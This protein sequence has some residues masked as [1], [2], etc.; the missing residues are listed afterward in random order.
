MDDVFLTLEAN[1]ADTADSDLLSREPIYPRST[2]GGIYTMIKIITQATLYLR[3]HLAS[4]G[5]EG[6]TSSGVGLRHEPALAAIPFSVIFET[7]IPASFSLNGV[8]PRPPAML[9]PRTDMEK[10]LSVFQAF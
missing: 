10:S 6:K 7:K 3:P 9:K 4:V 8:E 5:A 1:R 2:T